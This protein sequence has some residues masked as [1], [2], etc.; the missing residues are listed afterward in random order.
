MIFKIVILSS[1]ATCLCLCITT[2]KIELFERKSFRTRT[3]LF[4][5]GPRRKESW[6]QLHHSLEIQIGNTFTTG[7]RSQWERGIDSLQTYCK[8][9]ERTSSNLCFTLA[10]YRC[11]KIKC[12][13]CKYKWTHFS[14]FFSFSW[15]LLPL[16]CLLGLWCKCSCGFLRGV[17][18]ISCT[19]LIHHS[20]LRYSKN[21]NAAWEAEPFAFHEVP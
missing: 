4:H 9:K 15:F 21:S 13:L 2:C 10:F 11:F 1:T 18:A 5:V 12:F 16:V 3:L 17:Y 19:Q 20:L 8:N 14:F 6:S 7:V